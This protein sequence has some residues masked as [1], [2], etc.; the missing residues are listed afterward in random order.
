MADLAWLQHVATA[1][2]RTAAGAEATVPCH[3][4]PAPAPAHAGGASTPADQPTTSA[5]ASAVGQQAA[6]IVPTPAA[7]PAPVTLLTCLAVRGCSLL[8]GPGALAPLGWLAGSLEVLDLGGAAALGDEAAG[9]LAALTR[10]R[11]GAV[12]VGKEVLMACAV[13]RV[14][15]REGR[16]RPV[17]GCWWCSEEGGGRREGWQGNRDCSAV[18]NAGPG[19]EG[20]EGVRGWKQ[21]RTC[22]LAEHKCPGRQCHDLAPRS[23]WP[24]KGNT[25]PHVGMGDFHLHDLYIA[26]YVPMVPAYIPTS[27]QAQLH[28]NPQQYWRRQRRLFPPPLRPWYCVPPCHPAPLTH[29]TPQVLNLS[30]TAVGDTTLEAL[31]FGRRARAWAAQHAVAPPPEAAAWPE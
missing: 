12:V 15:G 1:G 16:W 19:R 2:M 13:L 29:G 14:K 26:L 17:G 11:V 23:C 21:Q 6:A 25:E 27:A 5:A 3:A 28:V 30:H 24:S 4:V 20:I 10:L 8:R 18:I 31:T 7:A 9:P 22:V